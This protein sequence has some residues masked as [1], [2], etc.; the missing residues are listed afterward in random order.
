MWLTEVGDFGRAL[1]S[2]RGGSRL[3]R[4]IPASF[5]LGRA[6]GGFGLIGTVHVT[7]AFDLVFDHRAGVL[8][9]AGRA[10]GWTDG[11][12]TFDQ[13]LGLILAALFKTGNLLL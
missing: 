8:D 13:S 11:D 9:I 5:W 3:E 10:R 1:C 4:Q 12:A 6:L 2:P 7:A